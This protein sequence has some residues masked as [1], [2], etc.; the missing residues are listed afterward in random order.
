MYSEILFTSILRLLNERGMTKQ[1]L[2]DLSGVSISFLTDL[3]RGKA[4]PSLDTMASIADALGVSVPELLEIT[5]ADRQLLDAADAARFKSS[6]P[7]GFVRLTAVL[8]AAKA[9]AVR[10]WDIEARQRIELGRKLT[11]LDDSVPTKK[12]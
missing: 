8:P 7:P 12:A 10:Q 9:Y 3:T 2:S 1:Q 5:D 6:L 4:N 11:T